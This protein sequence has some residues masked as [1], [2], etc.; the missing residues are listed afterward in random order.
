[1]RTLHLAISLAMLGTLVPIGA[2]ENKGSTRVV[3]NGVRGKDLPP[4]FFE[5]MK[6]AKKELGSRLESDEVMFVDNLSSQLRAQGVSEGAVSEVGDFGALTLAGQLP[7]V[8]NGEQLH[9]KLSTQYFDEGYQKPF[10]GY[11]ATVLRH[12]ER[13]VAGEKEEGPVYKA[14][15]KDIEKLQNRGFIPPTMKA[16]EELFFRQYREVM[17]KGSGFSMVTIK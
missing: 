13:H 4:M 15:K 11:W 3:L 7:I 10:A 6:I 1:M 14:Q 17:A 12:E 5:A 16:L 8:I 9:I 2:A